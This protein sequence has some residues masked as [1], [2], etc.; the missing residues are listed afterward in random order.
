MKRIALYLRVSTF[1]RSIDVVSP[2]PQTQDWYKL[3]LH[4]QDE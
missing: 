2:L 1:S 3:R 4:D